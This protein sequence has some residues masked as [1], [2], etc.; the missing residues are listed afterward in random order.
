MKT[1]LSQK[2]RLDAILAS[3]APSSNVTRI[4]G[5]LP[6]DALPRSEAPA[7]AAPVG[8]M[9][10]RVPFVVSELGPDV[11]PFMLHI[12]AAL[13]EK[14]RRLISSRTKAALQAAK[15]RGVQLG[16]PQLGAD[17][18]AA[19][20]DRDAAVRPVL[21]EL[22]G[23]TLREIAAHLTD[24]G[25]AAP[26]GGAWNNVTVMRAM[27]RLGIERD[28]DQVMQRAQAFAG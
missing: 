18:K 27:R 23:K 6:P 26:R 16:N 2:H 21:V 20:A 17:N 9:A 5:G 11:D 3:L 7:K 25:I 19:A 24:R 13:A 15:A 1:Y 28:S 10:Q 4:E 8:L 14:E 12:Y 22:A